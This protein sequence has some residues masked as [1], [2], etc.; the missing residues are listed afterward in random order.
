[1]SDS[2]EFKS[3]FDLF[4]CHAS[5][6]KKHVAHPLAV[7]LKEFGLSVWYDE[8][9]LN[10]GDSLSESIDVGLARSKYGVVIISP[11]FIGKKWAKRE[12]RGLVSRDVEEGGVILP[13]WHGISRQEVL[14]FSPPLADTVA[15]DT[16]LHGPEEIAIKLLK[17]I[18]PDIYQQH[19]HSELE[20]IANGEALNDLRDEIDRLKSE[21]SEYRCPYCDSP[22][23]VR[24]DAPADPEERHWDI[25]EVYECG[26]TVFGGEIESPCPSD[27]K[28]PKLD[29]YRLETSENPD[30]PHLQWSCSALPK[31]GM[32]RRLR[33]FV[34]YGETEDEARAKMFEK[35]ARMSKR[36][37]T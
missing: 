27:P 5:E 3:K 28:F 16:S 9:S 26:Y 24:I 32:A 18:R 36:W 7:T 33:L 23:S 13:V 14:E 25:R 10:V 31:T 19:P 6:D 30:K 34:E 37:D 15:L 8:F 11:E 1:M 21:L 12:L 20:R 29:E 35:Y 17:Q 2:Q 22:N 4:I